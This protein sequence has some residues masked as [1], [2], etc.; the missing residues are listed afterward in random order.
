MLA[1]A[2]HYAA[3]GEENLA[4]ATD[5]HGISAALHQ[6]GEGLGLAIGYYGLPHPTSGPLAGAGR[7]ITDADLDAILT[8]LRV[9]RTDLGASTFGTF[10][11]NSTDFNAA[12]TTVANRMKQVYGLTDAD[13]ENY[14]LANTPG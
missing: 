3:V 2:F 7:K 1:R 12:V 5:D 14:K 6:F 9:D 8:A 10:V 4:G 11:G 13:I